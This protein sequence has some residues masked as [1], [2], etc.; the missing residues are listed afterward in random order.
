MGWSSTVYLEFHW[1]AQWCPGCHFGQSLAPDQGPKERLKVR[2]TLVVQAYYLVSVWVNRATSRE[3]GQKESREWA[4]FTESLWSV[5]HS[6]G[7]ANQHI[8][9]QEPQN[10]H[11]NSLHVKKEINSLW[12]R[13]SPAH[14]GYSQ[15]MLSIS[16]SVKLLPSIQWTA[17]FRNI[18]N[19]AIPWSTQEGHSFLQRFSEGQNS[20]PF[21]HGSEHIQLE[22]LKLVPPR[23]FADSTKFLKSLN[24]KLNKKY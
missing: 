6:W 22:R 17:A 14:T 18:R 21:L 2:K 8:G 9:W 5:L 12:L 4:L 23:D 1:L 24:G 16:Y 20:K 15:W 13:R 19:S 3:M 10:D 11:M 7:H